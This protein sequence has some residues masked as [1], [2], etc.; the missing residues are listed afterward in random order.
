MP[1]SPKKYLVDTDVLE[2]IRHRADHEKL[3]DGLIKLAKAGAAQ[4]VPQV[5][6]ELKKHKTADGILR[7]HE[8]DFVVTSSLLYTPSVKDRI[9]ILGKQAA[10]LWEKLGTKNPDPADPWLVAV[11]SAHG[12]VV[13][14]DESTIKP[15]KIP[16]ACK[17]VG[18]SCQCISGPEL[19]YETGIVTEFKAEHISPH[20]FFGIPGAT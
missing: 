12:F 3:Y 7:P 11:A 8:K 4:T 10:F 20:K 5:F 2:H 13:V 16:A 9:T 19:L 6:G 15:K 17:L 1:P 14:T 18:I